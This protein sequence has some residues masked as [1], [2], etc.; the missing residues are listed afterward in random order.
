[1]PTGAGTPRQ[2]SSGVGDVLWPQF[3]PD[4]KRIY[5][6]ASSGAHPARMYAQPV[7]GGKAV[8]IS[9]EGY[10]GA[11]LPR[12]MSPDGKRLAVTGPQGKLMMIEVDGGGTP[13]QVP[14]SITDEIAMRW[15][16][17]GR[18][19]YTFVIGDVPA[20]IYRIDLQSGQR[21]VWREFHPTDTTGLLFMAPTAIPP[22]GTGYAY[23]FGRMQ[24][25]LF[26]VTGLR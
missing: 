3:F 26:V 13:R 5:Y 11:M 20:R 24:S 6:A 19:L 12:A 25:Q 14:G 1:V 22:D 8:P 2:I 23:T 21:Q 17:D 18:Y 9:P 7:D 16:A 10:G 15:S 4:G